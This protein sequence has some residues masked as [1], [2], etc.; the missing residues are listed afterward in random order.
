MTH[1]V[2][3]ISSLMESINNVTFPSRATLNQRKANVG[4]PTSQRAVA[5]LRSDG[6][7]GFLG[8]GLQI[9]LKIHLSFALFV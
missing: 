6:H 1:A 8:P 7:A 3:S 4:R 5:R 9:P 2:Q